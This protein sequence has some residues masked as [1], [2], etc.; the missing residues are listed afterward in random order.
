[1]TNEEKAKL[2]TPCVF[3]SRICKVHGVE[4][5]EPCNAYYALMEMA[6]WKD[7]EFD[8]LIAEFI[9]RANDIVKTYI[10]AEDSETNSLIERG[11]FSKEDFDNII[12]K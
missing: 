6:E 9:K 7:K 2:L 10:S 12:T 4:R 5:N 8:K 11:F 3:C 1:M